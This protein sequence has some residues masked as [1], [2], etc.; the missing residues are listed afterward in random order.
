MNRGSAHAPRN[1]HVG[2]PSTPA[3]R[4]SI[5]SLAAAISWTVGQAEVASSCRAGGAAGVGRTAAGR[6][7]F[8]L[9]LKWAAAAGAATAQREF[10]RHAGQAGQFDDVGGHADVVEQVARA[11]RVRAGGVGEVGE[12]GWE[13]CRQQ[14]GQGGRAQGLGGASLG[15]EIAGEDHQVVGA[16]G[17]YFIQSVLERRV[18][19]FQSGAPRSAAHGQ[20]RAALTQH[21]A[22]YDVEQGIAARQEAT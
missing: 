5:W 14:G 13:P 2:S 16:G 7:E 8:I 17:R 18:V 19:L 1:K 3:A 4:L 22:G 20:L 6:K 10:W 12:L 9:V 11:V 21:V 15:V